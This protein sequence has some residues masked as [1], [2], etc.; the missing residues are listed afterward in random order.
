MHIQLHILT[1]PFWFLIEFAGI[2]DRPA[3]DSVNGDANKQ[4]SSPLG[5]YVISNF[6][7]DDRLI[8]SLL[9]QILIF[10]CN[11]SWQIIKFDS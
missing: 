4:K 2:V 5:V 11:E 9:I 8:G 10:P 3:V 1:L 6:K 7:Y